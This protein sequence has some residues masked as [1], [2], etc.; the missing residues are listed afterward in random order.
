MCVSHDEGG[1]TAGD[2]LLTHDHATRKMRAEEEMGNVDGYV[3][4]LSLCDS[5]QKRVG[6]KKRTGTLRLV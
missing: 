3:D 1:K 5:W 2:S 6:W 4:S